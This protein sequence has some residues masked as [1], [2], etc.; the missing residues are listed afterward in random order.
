MSRHTRRAVLAAA[1]GAT[2][3][4]TSGTAAAGDP[5]SETRGR[6]T[7]DGSDYG[8][9]DLQVTVRAF[10]DS[11]REGALLSGVEGFGGTD[12]FGPIHDVLWDAAAGTALEGRDDAFFGLIERTGYTD[13]APELSVRTERRLTDGDEEYVAAVDTSVLVARSRPAVIT[14][15]DLVCRPTSRGY[16][17]PDG[18]NP[19]A[20]NDK[21]LYSVVTPTLGG[22]R[23]LGLF[24][25]GD[26]YD[27]LTFRTDGLAA[28]VA[29]EHRSY[30]EEIAV[31]RRFD[32]A[33]IGYRGRSSGP[34][35]SAWRDC[36][37]EADGWIDPS[38][39]A[40][41]TVDGGF[42]TFLGRDTRAV[43]E[44]VVGFGDDADAAIANARETIEAGYEVERAAYTNP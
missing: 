5:P 37:V 39:A 6:K 33:R 13:Y 1:A 19:A 24:E 7:V 10:R 17:G 43:R 40:A 2:T 12:L 28:A 25:E 34:G 16:P 27:Y 14:S 44:V 23:V 35:R 9:A 42:G 31:D 29:T 36:Y 3:L 20:D 15:A 21:T 4:G 32:G 38:H 18:D 11:G 8:G 30:G 41:G 22:G 26:R